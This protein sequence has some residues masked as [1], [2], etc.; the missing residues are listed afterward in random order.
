LAFWLVR[1]TFFGFLFERPR[2]L[3]DYRAKTA[4]TAA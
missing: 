3:L 1:G 4:A 2:A